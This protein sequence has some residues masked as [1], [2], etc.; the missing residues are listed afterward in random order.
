[1]TTNEIIE[2]VVNLVKQ[3]KTSNEGEQGISEQ[4]KALAFQIEKAGEEFVVKDAAAKSNDGQ[5]K[6]ALM[7]YMQAHSY[8]KKIIESSK[9]KQKKNW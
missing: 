1:M 4:Q 9:P 8:A 5:D 2:A 3:L 6:D 7:Q